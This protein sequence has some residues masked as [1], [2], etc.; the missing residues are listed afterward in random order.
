MVESRSGQGLLVGAGRHRR[1]ATLP[2]PAPGKRLA[3]VMAFSRSRYMIPRETVE[4]AIAAR[5][6]EAPTRTRA[7]RRDHRGIRGRAPLRGALPAHGNRRERLPERADMGDDD[8]VV[9]DRQ[10]GDRGQSLEVQ[11]LVGSVSEM[12]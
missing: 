5:I 1:V 2:P 8:E 11:H 4:A 7:R 10:R 3:R 12:N 6:G 9:L